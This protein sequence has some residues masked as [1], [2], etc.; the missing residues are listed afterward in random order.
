M[1]QNS[2]QTDFISKKTLQ[3]TTGSWLAEKFGATEVENQ[4]G[5][6]LRFF[7]FSP[8]TPTQHNIFSR[9]FHKTTTLQFLL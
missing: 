9:L 3:I 4:S 6:K 2:I 1:T 5:E 7:S 8:P